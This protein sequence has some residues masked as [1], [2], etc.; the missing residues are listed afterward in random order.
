MKFRLLLAAALLSLSK[1]V[2][3][4]VPS[5]SWVKG[6]GGISTD[7]AV[8]TTD[9]SGAIYVTGSFQQ[10]VDFDPGTGTT[11]LVAAGG[12]DIFIAKYSAS[13][14]F[15]WAHSMGNTGYDAGL[16]LAADAAGN[17]YVSG[18]FQGPLD[19]D[20]GPGTT[21][22]NSGAAIAA[23]VF[24]FNGTGGLVWARATASGSTVKCTGDAL[25]L[26]WAGNV[27]TGGTFGGTPDF[28]PGAAVLAIATKGNDDAF[29]TKLDTA[30]TYLWTQTWGG[31]GYDK[32]NSIATDRTGNIY[33]VG[34]FGGTVD[35]DPGTAIYNM[36]VP[37]TGAY[38]SSLKTTGAFRWAVKTTGSASDLAWSIVSD[39][40]AALYIAGSYVLSTDLDP[41]PGTYTVTSAGYDDPFLIKL[42]TLGAFSWGRA[43]G[44]P[45]Y[46]GPPVLAIDTATG[47]LYSFGIFRDSADLDPGPA[48][49]MVTDPY[50]TPTQGRG[51][52]YL[53]SLNLQGGFNWGIPVAIGP[54]NTSPWSVVIHP[55]G[56]VLVAGSFSDTT[57]FNPWSSASP[58]IPGNISYADAFFARYA[59]SCVPVPTTLTLS[60]TTVSIAPVSGATYQWLNCT[61]GKTPIAGQAGPS[62]TATATGS[63]AVAIKVQ[64][65]TDTSA[66]QTVTVCPTINTTVTQAG[67]LLSV[68]TTAGATYQW[69]NCSAGYAPLAGKTA[70]VFSATANGTYAVAVHLPN[71]CADTSQCVVV[72]GL[73]ITET[74]SPFG[75]LQVYPNAFNETLHLSWGTTLPSAK[76]TI[77]DPSGR[78]LLQQEVHGADAATL[79]TDALA[80]GLYLVRVS[81]GQQSTA[82]QVV[83]VD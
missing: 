70:T 34:S 36:T 71:G 32:L 4:Q 2:A 64:Q 38:V 37:G 1:P 10:T 40:K 18:A 74:G 25:S 61:T 44:G 78:T 63:Y 80:P 24:K 56:G 22:L 13:G 28:N 19:F 33:A 3:A 9:P 81:D 5:L 54:G 51:G 76:V 69:L 14:G 31:T 82:R 47:R 30:G 77:L 50:S 23:F 42:D 46:D 12:D 15:I 43:Y 11:N 49:S 67:G 58:L 65:C 17:V 73:G 41:G 8:A 45:S 83:K 62:F 60:G 6:V 59:T 52:G 48:T 72:T 39:G 79:A 68:A 66:C 20:P 16:A 27:Y 29:M 57:Y 35:F 21:V 7:A 75:Q 53:S 26:D 55:A